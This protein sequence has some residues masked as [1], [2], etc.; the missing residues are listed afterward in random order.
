MIMA[1]LEEAHVNDYGTII[2]VT[3]YDTTSTGASAVADISDASTKEFTFKRP[4]GTTFTKT[5]VFTNDGSDG[6]IQY[7]TSTDDLN[8][9]GTWAL[10][11]YVLT[12]GGFSH[13]TDV[14]NFRVF[15]NL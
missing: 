8:M 12:S 14:G 9:A 11:A 15:E 1:F 10:Q 6:Q 5:A 3:V 4:D 13:R 2:R 7:T